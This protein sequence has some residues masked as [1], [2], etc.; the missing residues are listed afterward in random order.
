MILQNRGLWFRL[1]AMDRFAVVDANKFAFMGSLLWALPTPIRASRP[2]TSQG[3]T[4]LDLGW[5]FY[6]KGIS[7][8]ATFNP[9]PFRAGGGSGMP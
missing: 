9:L 1:A 6:S 3:A 8:S 7:S 4:L 5:R 2:K